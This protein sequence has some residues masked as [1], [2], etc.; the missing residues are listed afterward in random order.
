MSDPY[1]P[2]TEGEVHRLFET[3]FGIVSTPKMSR[4]IAEVLN[5]RTP[6][7]DV[8][9]GPTRFIL[10]GLADEMR[11]NSERWFPAL[12]AAEALLPLPVFYALGLAGETGELVDEIK[13]AYRTDGD[14]TQREN[15][16][17]EA[18]DV[19]TYLLLLV[20]AAGIDLVQAYI[21]KAAFNE[22][23]WGEPETVTVKLPRDVIRRGSD[24]HLL[25]AD[26]HVIEEACRA[27]QGGER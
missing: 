17:A 22:E 26:L 1:K 14:L 9:G 18:A 11:T 16:A 10:Q 12:H 13:K 8:E 25:G 27:A 24:G 19:L 4:C 21:D 20:D 6:R 3:R 7:F 2:M 5:E 15:L 23:R